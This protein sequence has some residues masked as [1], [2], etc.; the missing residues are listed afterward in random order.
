LLTI[1]ALAPEIA[2][3]GIGEA[4]PT[5]AGGEAYILYL[6]QDGARE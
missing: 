6:L 3:K 2:K 4:R 5:V 1:A